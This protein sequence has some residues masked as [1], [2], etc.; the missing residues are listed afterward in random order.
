[1]P[2]FD[3]VDV[4][5]VP[6]VPA[7]EPAAELLV[8]DVD[9][10]PAP[11]R[12]AFVRM[13]DAPF[14]LPDA[15]RDA[16]LLAVELPPVEP[17]VPVAPAESPGCRQ[18]VT[19]IVPLSLDRFAPLWGDPDVCVLPACAATIAVQPK[20]MANIHAARFI[21]ASFCYRVRGVAAAK[22]SPACTRSSSRRVPMG[23]VRV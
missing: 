8:G 4:P 7:V 21:K 14:T 16:L 18:P 20:P 3:P 15:E 12:V 23:I 1:M 13:N 19:V 5:V 17:V 22:R 6:A 10:L 9:A 2:A 11:D